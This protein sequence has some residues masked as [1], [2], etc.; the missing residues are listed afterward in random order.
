M[1]LVGFIVDREMKL[2]DLQ[3]GLG[4]L[5]KDPVTDLMDAHAFADTLI[6]YAIQYHDRGRN[7]GVILLRNE[8]HA[9]VLDTYGEAFSNQVLR[10]MG[11][12]IVEVVGQNSV[13]ARVKG[14]I[15][16]VLTY[17]KNEEEIMKLKDELREKLHGVNSVEGNPI[18][19]RINASVRVRSWKGIT[20]EN[21]YED[22][23]REVMEEKEN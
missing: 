18:T 21:I 1:G 7:Y 4:A 8:K 9:R 2:A 22:A 5:K 6:D 14:S 3:I 11:K 19:T 13:V 15:F 20:D 12:V 23:L 17:V 10:Q 16:A